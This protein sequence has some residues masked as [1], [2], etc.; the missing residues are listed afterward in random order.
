MMVANEFRY[1][2]R[3]PLLYVALLATALMSLIFSV[4]IAIEE[5]HVMQQLQL[6]VVTILMMTMPLCIGVLTPVFFH[7]DS[8]HH[9]LE[10]VAATPVS[11]T[12][13]HLI[14]YIAAFASIGVIYLIAF[15]M[16][17]LAYLSK[18]NDVTNVISLLLSNYVFVLLPSILLLLALGLYLT[19][20]ISNTLV[21]YLIF[22][23]L[24]IGYL[25]VSSMTGTPTLAGSKVISEGF[26]NVMKWIDPFA[27]TPIIAQLDQPY[28]IAST[29]LLANRLGAIVITVGLVFIGLQTKQASAPKPQSLAKEDLPLNFA[30]KTT[31]LHATQPTMYGFA[32]TLHV[33]TASLT[34]I[35]KNPFIWLLLT[36]WTLII[37]T[38]MLAGIDYV[39]PFQRVAPTSMDALNRVSKDVIPLL[40]SVALL[41][42]TWLVCYGAKFHR[43]SEMLCASPIKNSQLIQ[44]QITTVVAFVFSLMSATFIAG[45]LAELFAQSQWQPQQYL[46][47]L[48]LAA[49]PLILLGS[50][51]VALFHIFKKPLIAVALMVTLLVFKF[52]SASVSLGVPHILW[53]I[54]DSPLQLPSKFWGYQGS[55]SVLVP[56][57]LMWFVVAASLILFASYRTHRG[58]YISVI[59]LTHIPKMVIALLCLVVIA[60]T[61]MHNQLVAE[62]P[63]FNSVTREDWRANYESTYQHWQNQPQPSITHVDANIDIYPMDGYAD[64]ALS[65]ELTNETDQPIEK[66]LIGSY[67]NAPSA[68]INVPTAELL[69]CDDALRQHVF[70]LSAPLLPGEVMSFSATLRFEHPKLWPAQMH[71]LVTPNYS[72]LRAV[73][74]IPEVGYQTEWQLRHEQLRDSYGLPELATN[75]PS[76]I[77]AQHTEHTGKYEWA[78]IN[79]HISTSA[80]QTAV[81][82]GKLINQYVKNDRA[83]FH[84][85]TQSAI[86]FIPAWFSTPGIATTAE[87]ND[88]QLQVF[89]KQESE[90]S[91]LHLKAMHD[92]L[93]WFDTNI[94]PYQGKQLSFF[95]A[96]ALG[97]GTAYALPQ[98]MMV[99][100]KH[101]FRA[102]PTEDAGFDQ[103]YRRAVH[104]TAHQ[105]FGH[106]IGNG[107][108]Y[109]KSFLIES[110]A[111]YIELVLV[112]KHQGKAAMQSLVAYEKQR[113]HRSRYGNINA[114]QPL[115]DADASSDVY[116][117]ASVVF[118]KL[119]AEIGDK[120]IVNALNVLWQ[121]HGY[122]NAPATS[123]DFVRELNSQVQ[124]SQRQLIN[125]LLIGTD[126]SLL[127]LDK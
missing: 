123:M 88:V 63:L 64:I 66:L 4:G 74:L 83:Y 20:R 30:S 108:V 86:R 31:S 55:S 15:I 25:M 73:P 17:A 54:A 80:D 115:V 110:M 21:I 19:S 29:Q 126:L 47:Q 3:Q 72:Y 125:E 85:Q 67:G 51:F 32:Q 77:F 57:W 43:T 68:E 70:K 103:R 75:N 41:F 52:T 44:V 48:S 87:Y 127:D 42:F 5:Y 38:E 109:D 84:Y 106:S 26:L 2:L 60:P 113:Y 93:K 102:Q 49:I 100:H 94:T 99:N 50:M 82:Q 89:V 27:F 124:P 34:Q 58:A 12:R 101:G 46:I 9:L 92:T 90:A 96:P 62:K 33:I 35:F 18:T 121:K 104:E 6:M 69:L 107:V 59:R 16:M 1:L 61:F 39:E 65:Y 36:C 111:K 117:R 56:Y 79:T 7:R 40:G 23:G 28:W 95:E 22:A 98:L 91:D 11:L 81:A 105:W 24:W 118:A 13:L 8:R 97:G 14:R 45:S 114:V 116:S 10:L 78:T 122:P 119:R 76:E 120:P 53:Q 71:Q 37:F 112:E